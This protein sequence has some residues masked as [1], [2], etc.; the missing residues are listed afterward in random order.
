MISLDDLM[1]G[2][3]VTVETDE[4]TV[5]GRVAEVDDHHLWLYE[6]DCDD[7]HHAREWRTARRSVSRVEYL[8]PRAGWTRE[9]ADHA[10]A[11]T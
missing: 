5:T 7:V 8:A 11:R 9:E 10:T 4:A 6:H 2:E 3:K 1:I